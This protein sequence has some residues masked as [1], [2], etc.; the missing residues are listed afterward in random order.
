MLHL[1]FLYNFLRNVAYQIV[2]N[3]LSK[4]IDITVIPRIVCLKSVFQKNSSYYA[5]VTI[6]FMTTSVL[7]E[8]INVYPLVY[9]ILVRLQTHYDITPWPILCKS[10]RKTNYR[11]CYDQK[12]LPLVGSFQIKYYVCSSFIQFLGIAVLHIAVRL[13]LF[14]YYGE[15]HSKGPSFMGGKTREVWDVYLTNTTLV[16][17]LNTITMGHRVL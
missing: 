11:A 2:Q 8:K 6:M 7:S 9:F 16:T 17:T 1:S 14:F 3:G 10:N 5:I 13:S 12:S 4:F 15:K